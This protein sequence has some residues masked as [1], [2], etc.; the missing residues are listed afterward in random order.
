M[1]EIENLESVF[2]LLRVNK[3]EN[4]QLDSETPLDQLGMD[5]IQMAGLVIGIED[6]FSIMVTDE[7]FQ[8]WMKVGDV[9]EYIQYYLEEYG[10][11]KLSEM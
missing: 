4:E 5:S 9:A 6:E 2:H 7:A 1:G 3:C 8:K 10:D 11:G